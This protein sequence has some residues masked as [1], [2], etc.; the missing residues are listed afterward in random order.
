M[1]NPKEL[2]P[3]SSPRAFYG[4]EL[5]F[6]R[7]AVGLSQDKLGERIFCSGA[8][9]GQIESATR[10]PQLDLSERLDE[11][12]GTNGYLARLCKMV[13]KTR[14]ADYF[15]EAAEHEANALAISEFA[16][17]IVPGLMQTAAYARAV[18]RSFDPVVSDEEIEERVS[19]RLERAEILA[20]PTAPLLWAVLDESVLRR[21]I[22]GAEVM[23]QQLAHVAEMARRNGII[24]QVLPYSAGAHALLEGFLALMRFADAPPLAYVEG[25]Y[26]GHLVEDPDLVAKSQLAYDLVRAAALS[27]EASLALIE[28]T[29]EDFGT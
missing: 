16:G 8:Y 10:K 4:G 13:N 23:R 24:V 9:I 11:A 3:S 18:L 17:A 6:V 22:G 5:R 28:S 19:A 14:H 15:A 1:A 21:L 2:D 26:T 25:L 7:E 12:L 20:G 29:M 27:P